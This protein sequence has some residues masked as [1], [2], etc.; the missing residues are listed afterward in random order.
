MKAR[1]LHVIDR[2]DAGGAQMALYQLARVLRDH[3]SLSI[4]VL[5]TSGHFADAYRSLGIPV[6]EIGQGIG[7]WNPRPIWNLM[8][9]IRHQRPDIIHAHLFK[10]NILAAI[11]AR[12]T[13]CRVILHD[14]VG[15]YPP[16]SE[17]FLPNRLSRLI[18]LHAYRY[19]LQLCDR[20]IVL[21]PTM[22]EPFQHYYS[23]PPEKIVLL[24]N[25]ID[26]DL[27][28]PERGNRLQRPLCRELGLP[29]DARFITMVGRLE[30]EKDWDT[31]LDVAKE[32]TIQSSI[33][34]VFIAVGHG[35]Q[36]ARLKTKA[37]N[38]NI[39]NVCFLGNRTDVPAILAQSD[40][41]LLTSRR[42]A[43]SLALLEA[44]A[45]GCAIVATRN[46]GSDVMLTDGID[47]LLCSVGDVLAISQA[48]N[49]LLQDDALY[50]RLR[51]NGLKTVTK[52]YSLDV[53]G[54]RMARVYTE[55]LEL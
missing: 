3:F 21:L 7:K 52:F 5:G 44:M 55:V 35:S 1:V 48:V 22:V 40:I 12:W 49:Y 54:E 13:G 29:P 26:L 31:F 47:G 41:F 16:I 53:I 34:C 24:P 30:P 18:Y 33:P 45:S 39:K 50:Q 9:T 17:V 20:L 51:S 15:L 46:G 38:N 43:C 23:L 4:V 6:D 25:A 10:S 36:A 19:A 11:A 28:S 37:Y 27:Y 42:E 8:R 2:A 32:L 14:H